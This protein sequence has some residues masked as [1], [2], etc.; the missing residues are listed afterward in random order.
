MKVSVHCHRKTLA[1]TVNMFKSSNTSAH[2]IAR[3]ND[4]FVAVSINLAFFT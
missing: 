2:A 1:S 4:C 3:H